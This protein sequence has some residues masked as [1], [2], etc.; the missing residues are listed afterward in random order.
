MNTLAINTQFEAMLEDI[1]EQCTEGIHQILHQEAWPQNL[2]PEPKHVPP[3]QII[4]SP[5]FMAKTRQFIKQNGYSP[6]AFIKEQGFTGEQAQL[7]AHKLYPGRYV[8]PTLKIRL[9]EHTVM[10]A[11]KV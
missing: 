3:I 9:N 2:T 10:P 1:Q 7:L 11:Y 8:S 5:V 6:M 4:H